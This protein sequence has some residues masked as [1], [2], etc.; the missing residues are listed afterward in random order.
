MQRLR[1]PTQR[2]ACNVYFAQQLKEFTGMAGWLKHTGAGFTKDTAK[3]ESAGSNTQAECEPL[4]KQMTGAPGNKANSSGKV[5]ELVNS[6]AL[7]LTADGN[8][9]G[10]TFH[11]HVEWC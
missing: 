3:T 11:E 10:K 1:G 7:E 4:M 9:E 2:N 6:L 5:I 8:A